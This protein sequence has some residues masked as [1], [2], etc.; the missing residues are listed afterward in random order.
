M[1]HFLSSPSCGE[2][3]TD[4]GGRQDDEHGSQED[5]PG[6]RV[7]EL[8]DEPLAGRCNVER[9]LYYT[10]LYYN[11][12]FIKNK[13]DMKA[14]W[15]L[16]NTLM[17]REN[18][19]S[20]ITFFPG[21]NSDKDIAETFSNH[22]NTV[23]TNI[24]SKIQAEKSSSLKPPSHFLPKER[25]TTKMTFQEVYPSEIAKILDKMENKTSYG[26]DLFSN[27]VLKYIKEEIK[28]PVCHLI[29]LSLK[30]DFVPNSWKVAKVV[31]IHKSKSRNECVNFRNVSLLSTFSKILERVVVKQVNYYLES[32]HILYDH[33]YGFRSGRRCESL[34]LKLNDIIF[35][36]KKA[37][38]HCVCVMLDISKAFDCVEHGTLLDKIEF[39][40][41][42][43][44]WFAN[45]L[46]GRTQYVNV[47]NGNS[48]SHLIEYGVP[49][50]SCLSP[51]LKNSG[52][53]C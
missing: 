43:R 37:R 50:G 10:I 33:Q 3:G 51:V 29:N 17:G 9:E 26:K 47:G 42:P 1:V 46:S 7:R 11:N 5:L 27:K 8:R 38:R 15:N 4:P 6:P 2:D 19:K 41:L 18:K 24:A 34:L 44:N 35:K 30:L 40:G 22:Y 36:A 49:Q 13:N 20:G 48:G 53:V 52:S 25:P 31:P 45:Y 32:N 21:C 28:V 23:A 12:Q 39:W 14:T 16:A